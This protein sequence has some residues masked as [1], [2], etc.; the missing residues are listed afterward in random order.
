MEHD[1]TPFWADI[2]KFEEALVNDPAS[3]C[4][5]PLAE[6]YRKMGLLDDAIHVAKKG[7]DVHPDYVGG[8]MALG[9][10]YFDKGMRDESRVAL[11][12]VVGSTPNNLL[13]RRILSQ[14]YAETGETA[15]AEECLRFILLHNPEDQES[16]LLLKSLKTSAAS[17]YNEASEASF[18]PEYPATDTEAFEFFPEDSDIIEDAEL[19]EELDDEEP[20]EKFS[21]EEPPAREEFIFTPPRETP[22]AAG[23]AFFAKE[24]DPL[25]TATM[26]ELYAS[27]GFLKRALTIYRELLENDPDNAEWN[28]RL[29]ELKT[30]IDED[31]VMARKVVSADSD[32]GADIVRDSDQPLPSLHVEE[33]S[34]IATDDRVL[35]ELGKWL[36]T[37]RRRR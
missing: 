1:V 37:I 19:L 4:F 6:L 23:A 33:S 21:A 18:R 27:Q 26:A 15:A 3:Y 34:P 7:C 29:Y 12:K 30:A 22:S 36:D 10:A 28:N 25:R 35:V 5:V 24:N 11:E 32:A 2:K 16:Q 17:D 9:R 14:I 31:M 8:F 20:A 13:A